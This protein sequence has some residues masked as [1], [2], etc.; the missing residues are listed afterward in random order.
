MDYFE[1]DGHLFEFGALS[2]STGDDI[3]LEC[4]DLHATE[5]GLVGII[6][7]GPDRRGRITLA[8]PVPVVVMRRWLELAQHDVD[9]IAIVDQL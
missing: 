3:V 5:G 1:A 8:G 6:R 4:Y 9:V 7:V 2:E